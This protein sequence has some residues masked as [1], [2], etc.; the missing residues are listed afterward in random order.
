MLGAGYFVLD[1]QQQPRAD[2][3]LHLGGALAVVA[4]EQHLLLGVH[5][6]ELHS[7]VQLPSMVAAWPRRTPKTSSRL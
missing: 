1:H 6:E 7:L 2:H 4:V 5:L 3:W